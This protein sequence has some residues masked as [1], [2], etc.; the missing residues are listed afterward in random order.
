MIHSL[1]LLD[2]FFSSSL[3]CEQASKQA[4]TLNTNHLPYYSETT[5]D[6]C[7]AQETNLKPIELALN[8]PQPYPKTG[9][10]LDPP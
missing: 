1:F 3:E 4:T 2:E 9:P 10:T 8:V 5:L 6:L 7:L